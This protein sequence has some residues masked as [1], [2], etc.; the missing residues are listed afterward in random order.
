MSSSLHSNGVCTDG[1]TSPAAGKSVNNGDSSNG[2]GHVGEATDD[3]KAS[4]QHIRN[5]EAELKH[6]HEALA[7]TLIDLAH[8]QKAR[9]PFV[10][11]IDMCTQ[12]DGQKVAATAMWW[13]HACW[14]KHY[15]TRDSIHNN[16]LSLSF[17]FPQLSKRIGKG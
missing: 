17:S 1:R 9:K 12:S 8:S 4:Q 10:H 15:W 5:L 14:L 16:V 13:R 7:G 11:S 3:V 2:G 6:A